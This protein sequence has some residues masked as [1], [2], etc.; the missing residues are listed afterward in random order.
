MNGI[1]NCFMDL[2]MEH[3]CR[4]D[5]G[6]TPISGSIQ[7]TQ[8]I[9][10]SP[11]S[12]KKRM[13]Y[14]FLLIICI[15]S[16]TVKLSLPTKLLISSIG[17]GPKQLLHLFSHI[18]YLIFRNLCTGNHQKNYV[19]IPVL[20]ENGRVIDLYGGDPGM[21]R[22]ERSPLNIPVVIN[23]GGRGTRLDPF[24]RVL[25]KPLIPVGDLPIT[26]FQL[27]RKEC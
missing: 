21:Q 20:D 2:N 23:A 14:A 11:L 1:R 6:Q 9:S 5:Q 16:E 24:T 13:P 3:W 15:A 27:L 18:L 4:S 10:F 25:P 8:P 12:I 26:P 7:S 19:V 22:K 17:K